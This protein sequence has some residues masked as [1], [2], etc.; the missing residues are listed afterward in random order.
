M[1]LENSSLNSKLC[2]EKTFIQ[3]VVNI[4]FFSHIYAHIKRNIYHN[5]KPPQASLRY[6]MRHTCLLTYIETNIF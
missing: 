1:P 3:N 6:I 4:H 2:I 5:V